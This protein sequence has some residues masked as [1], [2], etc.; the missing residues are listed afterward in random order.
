[1]R[2]EVISRGEISQGNF[3]GGGGWGGGGGNYLKNI[4]ETTK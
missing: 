4:Y 2:D 3:M 1:M